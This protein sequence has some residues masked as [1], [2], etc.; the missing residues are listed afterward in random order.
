MATENPE[1]AHG[2]VKHAKGKAAYCYIPARE[3]QGM[4]KLND[5]VI[6]KKVSNA[7]VEQAKEA[8]HE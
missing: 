5:L 3:A 8:P 1:W 2:I 6:I 7:P 4:F